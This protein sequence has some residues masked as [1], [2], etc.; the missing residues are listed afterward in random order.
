[1]SLEAVIALSGLP[2]Y[3][4]HY[5]EPINYS[6]AMEAAKNT[7]EKVATALVPVRTGFLQSTIHAEAGATSVVAF[8]D[9]DYAE[10]VEYG[11]YK[12]S[13]QPYF[14]PALSEA[15]DD[16]KSTAQQIELEARYE[17]KMR[18]LEERMASLQQQKEEEPSEF[19]MMLGSL[20][21][22]VLVSFL[23]QTLKAI[24]DGDEDEEPT[25][26]TSD[27]KITIK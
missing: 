8:A 17:D 23:E 10:Y 25:E 21:G 7:F 14:E 16:M 26:D 27:Y 5:K 24:Y 20:A 1:M 6:P 4:Q 9:A 18:W 15:L 11:T 13:P 19:M 3:T 2:L 12:Q 22:S